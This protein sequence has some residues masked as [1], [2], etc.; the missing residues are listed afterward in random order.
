MGV[1]SP[2][3]PVRAMESRR[4]QVHDESMRT[5]LVV[6]AA[7]SAVSLPVGFAMGRLLAGRT[8]AVATP[9][10]VPVPLAVAG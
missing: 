8:V 4:R 6:A 5:L 10:P 1:T 9:V 2:K 7:W 3:P